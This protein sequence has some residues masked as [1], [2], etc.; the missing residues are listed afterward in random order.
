MRWLAAIVAAGL[1]GGCAMAPAVICPAGLQTSIDDKLYF[2]TATPDG[3][4]SAD[5]WR[6]FVD[7]EVTP[8]FPQGLTVTPATGQ[9]QSGAGAIVREASFVLTL[10]HPDQA[11]PEAAV[12]AIVDSYKTRFRQE[13]VLRVRTPTCVSF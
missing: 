8:R 4:V 11:A 13:A 6:Q 3:V 7:R 12:Q 5:D 9:W 10:V 2:G 1:V